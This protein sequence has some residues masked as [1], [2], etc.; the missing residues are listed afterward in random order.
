MRLW[1][2]LIAV[3]TGRTVRSFSTGYPETWKAAACSPG[4]GS[5]YTPQAPDRTSRFI[6]ERPSLSIVY[7]VR[8]ERSVRI[9]I[10]IVKSEPVIN[11]LEIRLKQIDDTK[12]QLQIVVNSVWRIKLNRYRISASIW[13]MILATRRRLRSLFARPVCSRQRTPR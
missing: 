8:T 12:S 2:A 6:P 10:Q 5:S 4:S 1:R 9:S 7:A 3:V 13:R 11:K